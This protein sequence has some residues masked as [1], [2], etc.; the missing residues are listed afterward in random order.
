MNERERTQILSKVVEVVERK[1]VDPK[2]NGTDFR[3]AME[4]ARAMIVN[5]HSTEEFERGVNSLFQTLG[6]S[7]TG[8]FHEAKP[9][10][11]GR[12]A[13]SATFLAA[14]TTDGRRWVFQDVHP[15]GVAAEAGI[16]PG[17]TLLTLDR[18]EVAP[19]QAAT[20]SFGT[21][22]IATI[23]RCDGATADIVLRIPSSK[24][25]QR[26]LIVP[27]RVVAATKLTNGCGHLRV[28]MFPGCSASTS[29]AT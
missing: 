15:G 11:P 16:R 5:A 22:H 24:D 28:S 13:I 14:D 26:P 6:A 23:R 12:I 25:K 10:S 19:P 29:R 2:L 17:D 4:R 1:F 18:Q 27:S 3:G 7:H 20:F 9:R 8:F 21:D